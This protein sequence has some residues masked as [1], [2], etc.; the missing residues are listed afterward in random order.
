MVRVSLVSLFLLTLTAVGLAAEPAAPG[1]NDRCPVCGM[2]VA[3]YPEWIATMT[4][5]DG[6]QIFF[7]GCKDLFRYYFD[8]TAEEQKRIATIHVTEYYSTRLMRAEDLF[9][10]LGSDV[11]GPM[12][13]ELIPVAGKENAQTFLRDHRGS[14]ILSFNQL[15]AAKLPA[16]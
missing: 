16:D 4:R 11:L 2:F 13:R 1:K 7:D 3:P 6:S 5:V 15:S 9:F 8:Q 12:G 14:E 10:V